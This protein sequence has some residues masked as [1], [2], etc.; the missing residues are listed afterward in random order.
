MWISPESISENVIETGE[1]NHS[2]RGTAV[3]AERPLPMADSHGPIAL[4]SRR[5]SA[6]SADNRRPYLNSDN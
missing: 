2:Q 5:L 4:L 6:R 3:G 1:A